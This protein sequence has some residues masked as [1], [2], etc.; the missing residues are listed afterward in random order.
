MAKP[1]PTADVKRRENWWM[2]KKFLVVYCELKKHYFCRKT[3]IIKIKNTMKNKYYLTKAL[4]VT[5]MATF[6]FTATAV[7]Q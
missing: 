6:F 1:R 5:A 3:F 2:S 7:A 4:L